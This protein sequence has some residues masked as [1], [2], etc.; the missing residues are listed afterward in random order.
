MREKKKKVLKKSGEKLKRYLQ[1]R[2]IKF[3]E[4]IERRQLEEM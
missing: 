2:D 3:R 4:S 1:N